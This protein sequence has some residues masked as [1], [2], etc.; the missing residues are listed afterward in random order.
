MGQT[1][2]G[3][4]PLREHG[5]SESIVEAMLKAARAQID[6]EFLSNPLGRG[7][8]ELFSVNSRTLVPQSALASMIEKVGSGTALDASSTLYSA[9]GALSR[10][11]VE[12]RAEFGALARLMAGRV[13][14]SLAELAM[15]GLGPSIADLAT[16]RAGPTLAE[17][18]ARYTSP[19]LA[20]LA[21][22]IGGGT[23]RDFGRSMTDPVV[24]RMAAAASRTVEA[25]FAAESVLSTAGVDVADLTVLDGLE[26]V[27]DSDFPGWWPSST[28]L[29]DGLRAVV[30]LAEASGWDGTLD[31][32]VIPKVAHASASG[33]AVLLAH[34]WLVNSDLFNV[35]LALFSVLGVYMG[36]KHLTEDGLE[37][38]TGS[39]GSDPT[40]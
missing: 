40:E 5:V 12:Q 28:E 26:P 9:R 20:Q 34:L 37:P 18:G 25:T 11:A 27:D 6:R 32:A 13:S 19:S 4:D 2:G 23:L 30:S 24:A 21:E 7:A 39:Q 14:P 8:E 29:A 33:A 22:T 38:F 36:V 35:V 31:P 1:H 17:F 3:D 15:Q 10:L 16:R